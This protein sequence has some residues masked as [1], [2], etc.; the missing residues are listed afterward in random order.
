LQKSPTSMAGAT[1]T[2]LGCKLT[3][4]GRRRRGLDKS[5]TN[6]RRRG[7]MRQQR[8]KGAAHLGHA[9]DRSGDE[10][11]PLPGLALPRSTRREVPRAGTATEGE[12]RHPGSASLHLSPEDSFGRR[13]PTSVIEHARKLDALLHGPAI[14]PASCA[15]RPTSHLTALS[16]KSPSRPPTCSAHC[17][18]CSTTTC[19]P[20]PRTT[21]PPD[22][23]HDAYIVNPQPTLLEGS[24]G[25]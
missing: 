3:H 21:P 23:R 19:P 24:G 7:R 8:L 11:A 1:P 20:P 17:A 13:G 25:F 14:P 12:G 4:R 5:T 18:T 2:S 15:T 6:G 9:D 22:Q 16:C 10:T